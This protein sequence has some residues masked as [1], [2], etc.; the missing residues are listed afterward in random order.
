M[1]RIIAVN[2]SEAPQM[3]AEV[4]RAGE[5]IVLPTDTVYGVA[6]LLEEE[7]IGRIF[8]AKK[9]PLD[10]AIPVLLADQSEVLQV[11]SEF[12]EMARRLAEAFWPGPLTMVLPKRDDLPPSLSALPTVGVRV[13]G[14]APSRA[15]IAAAGGAL[16][17]TSANRSDQPPACTI[18][19]CIRYLS[20]AVALYLD[21]GTCPGGVASTVV[22]FEDGYLRI[23]RKG[24][25]S[26]ASL[27]EALGLEHG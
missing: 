23:V 26:E 2:Y 8:A 4:L 18:Q 3:A 11:V 15:I 20:D 27:R 25:I 7:A 12:P 5:L 9:R 1:S 14:Y 6:S 13:P 16:A 21:G 22:A 10:R 17:V 24:P 19:A